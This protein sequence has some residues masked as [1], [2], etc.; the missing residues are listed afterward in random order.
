MWVIVQCMSCIL[1][2]SLWKQILLII[3]SYDIPI[4]SLRLCSALCHLPI[5]GIRMQKTNPILCTNLNGL[6]ECIPLALQPG[7]NNKITMWWQERTQPAGSFASRDQVMEE[8]CKI[9]SLAERLSVW[10]SF[11]RTSFFIEILHC[12]SSSEDLVLSMNK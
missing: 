11:S 2:V 9:Y 6:Q 4:C 12:F 8:C 7:T 5:S 1:N 3:A 10:L